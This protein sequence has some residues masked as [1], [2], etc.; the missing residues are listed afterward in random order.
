MS[1]YSNVTERDLINLHK[2]AQQQKEHRAL[3]IKN[4]ILE[5]IH[6]IK[7]AESLSPITKKLDEVSTSA[8]ESLLPINTKLDTLNK[9]TKEKGDIIK[10]TNFP[11]PDTLLENILAN[12]KNNIGFF[13]I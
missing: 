4:R 12:M 6:D 9:S 7:L 13:N 2:L 5:K 11:Q 8:Q 1:F 3:K 10:E